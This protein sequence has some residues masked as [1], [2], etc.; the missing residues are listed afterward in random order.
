MGYFLL[1][2]SMLD[3]VLYARDKWLREGG[4]ILPNKT[5]LNIAA[6]NDFDAK[7]NK[8]NFWNNVYGVDMSCIKRVAISEPSLEILDKNTIVSTVSRI[9][10]VDISTAKKEDLEFSN[11]YDIKVL[12]DGVINGIVAWFDVFFDNLPNKISFST[13]PFSKPTHWKQTIFYIRDEFSAKKGSI[14]IKARINHQWFYRNTEISRQF[15]GIR[16]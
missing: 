7:E 8:L 6:I 15:Q 11:V 9:Y 1:F 14:F 16:C 2:E 13:S 12:K 4:H 3:T 10:D 5:I